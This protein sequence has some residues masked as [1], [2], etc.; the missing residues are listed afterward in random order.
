MRVGVALG[1]NLGNRLAN[2]RAARK[3]I[4]KLSGIQ[5]DTL[6][7]SIYETE[8]IDCEPGADKF[9]NAVLEF[10]YEGDLQSL[11]RNLKAIESSLGRPGDHARNIS[12]SIDID[13]LYADEMKIDDERLHLP[14]PRMP[15]RRFVLAPLAEIRPDLILPNQTKTVAQLLANLN[16]SAGVVRREDQW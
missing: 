10:D 5:S 8:P 14:H 16:D 11:L 3:A 9:F 7:S 4:V 15:L 12:R 1:S 6:F 13:L 2:L